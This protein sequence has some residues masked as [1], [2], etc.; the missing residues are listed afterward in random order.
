[1]DLVVAVEQVVNQLH[2][3]NM[4]GLVVAVDIPEEVQVETEVKVMVSTV[5]AVEAIT[6]VHF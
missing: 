3:V 6:Q 4:D 5:V 2:M 1:V